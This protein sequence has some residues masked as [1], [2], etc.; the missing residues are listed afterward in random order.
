MLAKKYKIT[1]KEDYYKLYKK[2]HTFNSPC[3]KIFILPNGL[4]FNRF[5]IVVS[6]KISSKATTRN[7]IKRRIKGAIFEDG[8]QKTTPSF[9]I[10]IL[11][12]PGIDKLDSL[13]LKE[14]FK[15]LFKKLKHFNFK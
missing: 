5:S 6:K 10:L 2:G 8:L 9:D 1:K 7:N 14:K 12:Y 3:L 13:F 15:K 11:T 4:N